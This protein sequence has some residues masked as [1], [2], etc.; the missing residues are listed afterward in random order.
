MEVSFD[1]KIT[2]GVLY[3]YLLYHTYTGTTGL[4]GT[5]AG[6]LLVVAYFMAG[7]I[8]YLIF[9]VV[10]LVYLPWTLFIR[11]KKQYLANPAF[12]E[13]L[14]YTFN[15]EG[16]TVSQKDTSGQIA[17]E[18]LY[19]AVSTPKSIVIYT[20]PVNASI[21]PKKDLG[22]HKAALIEVIST[23]MPPK[24]VKIRGN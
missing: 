1:V 6:A 12:K 21:F 13:S 11:S 8:L 15:E 14:H 2:P 16:M 3:D 9:G 7:S 5:I 4:L 18:N 19:K 17:W 23:H 24:K 20:S 10:V 22:E